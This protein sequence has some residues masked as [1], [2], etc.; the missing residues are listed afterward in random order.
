MAQLDSPAV[1]TETG[2]RFRVTLAG[3]P[4]E[5]FVH[6]EAIHDHA[7]QAT[8]TDEQLVAHVNNF[9]D[10]YIAAAARKLNVSSQTVD[11]INILDGDRI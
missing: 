6:R 8:L 4:R 7:R 10:Q 3:K 1:L 9:A 5:V 11:L 2:V